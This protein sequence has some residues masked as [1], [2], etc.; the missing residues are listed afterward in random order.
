M[1]RPQSAHNI[2]NKT[3]LNEDNHSYNSEAIDGIKR[4]IMTDEDRAKAITNF[5]SYLKK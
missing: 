3:Q 5:K 4:Q 2:N 1:A